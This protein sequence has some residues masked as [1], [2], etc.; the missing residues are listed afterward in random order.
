MQPKNI[1][2]S[3]TL[4]SGESVKTVNKAAS[5]TA[6]RYRNV[7]S[8]F[9]KRLRDG[10]GIT[11]A[12]H[13]ER[14]VWSCLRWSANCVQETI[15]VPMAM[16]LA[17]GVPLHVSLT[18]AVH[19]YSNTELWVAVIGDGC[20]QH[21]CELIL[22]DTGVRLNPTFSSVCTAAQTARC[23]HNLPTDKICSWLRSFRP[24]WQPRT[25]FFNHYY[26]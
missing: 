14:D 22:M 2:P 5:T 10:I 15:E 9:F 24:R 12:E 13:H 7:T 26:F 11:S 3:P 19:Q 4:S 1:T 25:Y 20:P 8:D 23:M 18:S 16:F 21:R 6:L 17:P